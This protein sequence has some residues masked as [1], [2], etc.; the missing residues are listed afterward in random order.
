MKKIY[1]F[2]ADD[3][4]NVYFL[5]NKNPHTTPPSTSGA[6]GWNTC[7]HSSAARGYWYTVTFN[8]NYRSSITRQFGVAAH[9]LSIGLREVQIYGYGM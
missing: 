1:I 3:L 4:V 9:A 2:I 7:H 5:T 8:R 6:G